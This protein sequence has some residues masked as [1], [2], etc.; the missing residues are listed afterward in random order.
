MFCK[1]NYRYT[2]GHFYCT[3]CGRKSYKK[4]R[5]GRK[6]NNTAYV[7][8]AGI[9]IA[10][11]VI[12]VV[13]FQNYNVTIG[14]QKI[15]ATIPVKTLEDKFDEIYNTIPAEKIQ[16]AFNDMQEKF[17]IKIEPK[18]GNNQAKLMDCTS[19]KREYLRSHENSPRTEDDSVAMLT[20]AFNAVQKTKACEKYNKMIEMQ[21]KSQ[22]SVTST[23][24]SNVFLHGMMVPA[25]TGPDGV[26]HDKPAITGTFTIEKIIVS[27]KEHYKTLSVALNIKAENLELDDIVFISPNSITLKNQN[28]KIYSNQ[29]RE[30]SSPLSYQIYGKTG[31]D[32]RATVCYDVEKQFDKFDVLFS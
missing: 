19:Y 22:A 5:S 24:V 30:C 23:P 18:E 13:L 10:I 25:W 20:D 6:N 27:E 15:D 4:Y 12:A 21:Q 1:H 8:A 31:P 11:V 29:P 26:L 2:Q 14:N 3:K 7:A 9:G 17:P 28:G 32:L 16:E